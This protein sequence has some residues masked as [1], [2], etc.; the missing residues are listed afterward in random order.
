MPIPRRTKIVATIGPATESPKM[1]RRLIRAGV[2]VVRVNFSH[3]SP[4]EHIERARNIREAAEKVGRHVGILADL[5]GPKIRIERFKDGF[6]DL[7]DNQAFTLDAALGVNEGDEN[8][9]GLT[10]K[11][12]AEDVNAGDVLLLDDGLIV[13]KVNDVTGSKIN[14]TVK[15]G[16]KL[17]NH[18]GVNRQGGGLSAGALTE[19]DKKDIK[20]AAAMEA[21]FLAVS[22]VRSAEDVHEARRLLHEA[23]S[24]AWIVSKIERAEA[25]DVIEEITLASDVLMVARGDLGVEIGDA[26]IT[27][28]QKKIISQGRNLDRVVITATQMLESMIDK[29]MPTRAEVTDVANAVLDGTDAVMLSAETAVGKFPVKA[30]K[31][32]DR[33]CRGAEKHRGDIVRESRNDESFERIDEA[34]AKACMYTANRLHVRAIVAM[35][36]SGATALWMSRISSGLP[37]YA[38]SSQDR[39]L[40]Q[41]SMYRGVEPIKFNT[42]SRSHARVNAEVL[43]VLKERGAI[44]DGDTVIISKGD[45]AG[46][47]GG[48]NAMKILRVGYDEQ[49]DEQ[50]ID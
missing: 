37:I 10:Y 2:D 49:Q 1:L 47:Q 4:E 50:Q 21:D 19:K 5:Q 31:A 45:L 44:E 26:E 27:A 35:T 30:I 22:F 16:G 14:C 24:D 6:I 8:A 28:V 33:I 18:K 48:T 46:K 11:A 15:V 34:I 43:K 38:M 32:M 29:Q 7:E 39:T 3:G 41:A 40:R 20:L 13:L 23:G 12:L 9:V 42:P 17:S 25:I 36:E